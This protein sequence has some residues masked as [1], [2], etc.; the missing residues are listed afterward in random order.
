[1][2]TSTL[3]L[4]LWRYAVLAH[5]VRPD[6]ADEEI[7]L[8]TQRL[9]PGLAGYPILIIAGLF[10]PVIAVIGYLIIAL[11]L[12]HHPVPRLFRQDPRQEPSH[13]PRVMLPHR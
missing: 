4:V 12:L 10:L 11:Y 5:L 7:Q 8:L 2:L 1:V 9:T 13:P 3:L 6:A